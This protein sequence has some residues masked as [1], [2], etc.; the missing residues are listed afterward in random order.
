MW[1]PLL[2]LTLLRLIVKT[3]SLY[4]SCFLRLLRVANGIILSSVL[5]FRRRFGHEAGGMFEILIGFIL[6]REFWTF[7]NPM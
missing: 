3:H 7:E 2:C 6:C 1:A 5:G 4:I